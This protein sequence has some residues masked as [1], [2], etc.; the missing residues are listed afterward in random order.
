[1]NR[2]IVTPIVALS[3]LV[4]AMRVEA[5]QREEQTVQNATAVLREIMSNTATRIPDNMLHDAYGVMIV[6]SL[7]KGGFV[8]GARY[9]NGV[10]LIRDEQNR[11]HAPSFV[12]LTGANVGFQA[13][14]QS[15]DLVLVFKTQRGVQNILS[16]KLTLGADAAVAAGP[17][18]REAAAATDARLNAE[19]FS[20]SRS[21][22]LFA[23]VSLDGSVINVDNF[24]TA[25]YYHQGAGS[26][27]VVPPAAAALAQLVAGY[28][29]TDPVA[30]ADTAA[31][32]T[33]QP[34]P[35]IAQSQTEAD[36]LRDQLARVAPELYELVDEQW[37]QY[38]ALPAEIFSGQGHPT[39]TAL[40]TSL[41]HFATVANDPMYAQLSERP[42]FRSTYGL[43]Q[44]YASTLLRPSQPAALPGLPGQPGSGLAPPPT[45]IPGAG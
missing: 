31:R 11:W 28:A 13:G 39:E 22:G 44:H 17:L 20:Y 21:R 5:Q 7:I 37:K 19:I 24:A 6:P 18:G 16:G 8:I 33:A 34:S 15:I 43:L 32:E 41:A 4:W 10:L 40:D 1:M 38:L 30:A 27:V 45:S 26:T 35:L 14:L 2:L 9:G 23:G 3:T 42:E 12:T 36:V 25:A 29:G